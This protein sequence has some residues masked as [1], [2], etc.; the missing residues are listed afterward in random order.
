MSEEEISAIIQSTTN[1][2]EPHTAATTLPTLEEEDNEEHQTAID[3]DDTNSV[4]ADLLQLSASAIVTG[5]DSSTEDDIPIPLDIISYN[6]CIFWSDIE[7]V[8]QRENKK[9]FDEITNATLK[10]KNIKLIEEGSIKSNMVKEN[11][12]MDTQFVRQVLGYILQLDAQ[13]KNKKKKGGK[14]KR[15]ILNEKA[16]ILLE[17]TE[18]VVD[19]FFK[20]NET[21]LQQGFVGQSG[22]NGS[23]GGSSG[24]M[25]FQPLFQ[26]FQ[27]LQENNSSQASNGNGSDFDELF[28]SCLNNGSPT[29]VQT[30]ERV[31]EL[32]K[33]LEV[34]WKKSNVMS[35]IKVPTTEDSIVNAE[36]DITLDKN[37]QIYKLIVDNVDIGF[38][39]IFVLK[40]LLLLSLRNRGRNED[41]KS[42]CTDAKEEGP[43]AEILLSELIEDKK[44]KISKEDSITADITSFGEMNKK[45]EHFLQ[46][47]F[48]H[49]AN[50][51]GKEGKDTEAK[52]FVLLLSRLLEQ[53]E[54]IEKQPNIHRTMTIVRNSMNCVAPQNIGGIIGYAVKMVSIPCH[55]VNTMEHSHFSSGY[56]ADILADN[57]QFVQPFDSEYLHLVLQ[58]IS[59]AT[60]SHQNQKDNVIHANHLLSKIYPY[61]LNNPNDKQLVV[62]FLRCVA[63]IPPVT[64][65]EE[66]SYYY[67]YTTTTVLRQMDDIENED[68][69]LQEQRKILMEYLQQLDPHLHAYLRQIHNSLRGLFQI[70]LKSSAGVNGYKKFVQLI[71]STKNYFMLEKKEDDWKLLIE[72]ITNKYRRLRSFCRMLKDS[73]LKIDEEEP[74][75]IPMYQMQ[76][77]HMMPQTQYATTPALLP[78]AY[79]PPPHPLQQQQML[80]HQHHQQQQHQQQQ[81]SFTTNHLDFDDYGN[82]N[83]SDDDSKKRSTL[84]F[85]SSYEPEKQKLR[86]I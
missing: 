72:Y 13:Q 12:R 6:H 59:Y 20:K 73:A 82:N 79:P 67:S 44:Q 10:S 35:Y 8:C 39:L 43:L 24:N 55:V 45:E 50:I 66:T 84:N 51:K 83:E 53:F 36:N 9:V 11:N 57:D 33:E 31:V 23:V 81:V 78:Y 56:D 74:P 65:K 7:E 71:L 34:V 3:D 60:L 69:E 48:E 38:G 18:G 41:V 62:N 14:S 63:W 15:D 19:I 64:P 27:P 32:E 80:Q 29:N 28:G 25:V 58:L 47:C 85:D 52:K 61:I 68:L 37:D 5:N 17:I 42:F 54:D 49:L 76:P 21:T 16:R 4:V 70:T 1:N 75:Q 46:R 77:H 40:N 86:L 22:I 30:N 2:N 26:P